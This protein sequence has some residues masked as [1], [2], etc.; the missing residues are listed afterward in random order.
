MDGETT[1]AQVAVPGRDTVLSDRYRLRHLVGAGGMGSVWEAEDLVL[2]R[3]VA[4]KL[5]QSVHLGDP[6]AAA[7]FER[8]AQTAARLSHPHLAVVYDYGEASDGMFLVMELLD[9]ET[10]AQRLR[11]G[12]LAPAEAATIVAAAAE[13]L[14]AAHALGVVHRDVKPANLMLTPNGV[15]V[16]DFGIAA[17]EVDAPLTATGSIIGTAPYLAP[18]RVQGQMATPAS[19]VYALGAV[20]FEAL[21]GAP[22]FRGETPAEVALAHVHQ[23]APEVTA[24]DPDVPPQLAEACRTA[25]AKDPRDRPSAAEL[26]T[27]LRDE[28]TRPLA[29]VASVEPSWGPTAVLSAAADSGAATAVGAAPAPHRPGRGRLLLVVILALLVLAT[30]ALIAVGLGRHDDPDAPRSPDRAAPS[31]TTVPATTPPATSPP[32]T[33]PPT[34]A[35]ASPE[36]TTAPEPPPDPE[37][38]LAD[39][40]VGYLAAL[41][42]GDLD[43]AWGRTSPT[44]QAHQDRASWEA[45]WTSFD[46]I[47]VVGPVEVD[48]RRGAVR[49]PLSF[50]GRT[51]RY[52]MTL[53]SGPSGWLVDGPIGRTGPDRGDDG[54]DDADDADDADDE[55]DRGASGPPGGGGPR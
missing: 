2:H 22:A 7:R 12:A 4:V 34:T 39:A 17:F 26:A 41:A 46:S 50:D 27:R 38:A 40:A 8:E 44:F 49:V 31:P 24:A 54:G 33:T 23:A 48:G 10:L 35:P 55:G 32:T 6:V 28:A 11:D 3:R 25:L 42:A 51:E 15:K 9:G 29:P 30:L 47:E 18:E 19:D 52:R 5:L 53:V 20:L 13:A 43:G 37:A 16:L 45:F 14:A 36:T 21:T 1:R